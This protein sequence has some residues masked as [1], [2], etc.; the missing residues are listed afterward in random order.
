MNKISFNGL[1]LKEL[2]KNKAGESLTYND[3][4]ILPGFSK[5]FSPADVNLKTKLTRKISLNLPIVSSPMDTVTGELLASWL[6]LL[7]GIGILHYNC[8]ISEQVKMVES[9]KNF[10]EPKNKDIDYSLA[11]RNNNGRLLVGAAIGTRAEDQKRAEALIKAGAD[12]LVIDS[13]HAH[14][15]FAAEMLNF[16]KNKFPQIEVVAGNVA[17]AEGVKFLAENGADAVKVGVGSGSICTTQDV[18]GVGRGQAT[19]VWQCGQAANSLKTPIPIIADGGITQ[20][21]DLVKALILGA[22]TG[23]LGNLLASAFESLGEWQEIDGLRVKEYRGM[24]SKKAMAAGSSKRY[25]LE[26]SKR[27]Q[28][29]EGVAGKIIGKG[30]IYDLI[31]EIAA[32]LKQALFKIGFKNIFDLQQ[33]AQESKVRVEYRSEAAKQEGSPH[34]LLEVISG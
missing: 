13:A 31:P 4:I 9:V 15:T 27:V 7:G 18:T 6:A 34:N 23:M 26:N 30:H 32:G 14:V 19:A 29:A 11:C 33:A 5:G 2:F 28:A 22:S 8:T 16:L 21:G 3:F 12:V 20:T 24:G 1:S 10:K 17:T 25:Q